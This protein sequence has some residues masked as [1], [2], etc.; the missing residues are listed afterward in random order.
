MD[1]YSKLRALSR[2][3]TVGCAFLLCPAGLVAQAA[4]APQAQLS[5]PAFRI[6]GTVV[7]AIG[8]GPLARARVTIVDARNR[9]NMQSLITSDD[10]RFDFKQVGAGKYSLQGAKRG[11]IPGLY[12]EHEQFSTAI[13]PGAGLDTENLVLRLAPY[14]VLSGKILDELGDPVREATV[15]L[16]RENRQ[17]GVGRIGKFRVTT[18]DDQ[19][20]Y[21]F[22]GLDAGSYF[23]SATAKP[24]YALHPVSSHFEGMEN[25]PTS[26]D[27]SLD[28]AY[29]VT[30]Y[31][32]S[33]EPDDATPIPI[34]GGDHLQADIHLHPVPALH[35]IFH[36]PENSDH[37][38]NMPQL[39]EPSFDGSEYMRPNEI[40][41]VSPGVFEMSGIAPGRY[42][43][44]TPGAGQADQDNEVDI[45][46]NG[47][48]LDVPTAQRTSTVKATIQVL[49]EATLPPQIE[50]ALRNSKM[51]IVAWREM[52]EKGEVEFPG[53]APGKYDVLAGSRPKA[54]SVVQMSSDGNVIAGHT[55]NVATGAS[56][57]L[58][59]S[60]AGGAVNVEG[61][62]KRAGKPT[63]GAMVVLVPKDPEANRELFR[64]DQS[65]QDGSFL[66]S[67]I[68][69]GT[70]TIVAI[71]NGWDL[72]WSR[73]GVIAHYAQHGQTITI[74]NKTQTTM[75]LPDP[76]E[77]QAR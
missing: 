22:A 75:H 25:L 37:N 1:D 36:I 64:R 62:A 74:T 24:W 55:L 76:V 33:T 3:L 30:Y 68:I 53:L 66:L 45:T 18:T 12:D 42:S 57:T 6:A 47:Q 19:G 40:Q 54:Y 69:P 44:R 17:S 61:F 20:I 70:Y 21:E 38:F 71:E 9:K 27:Q 11:F 73:P 56:M 8:G 46:T 29:P 34:R 51:R 65:D 52:D 16:Y 32:D 41:Q 58:T 49:G 7:N 72:D 5:I 4:S 35:L 15:S 39:Q 67:S 60:L 13:V 14:A 43:V 31:G 48:E 28:A 23:I 63:S 50:I 10:G 26:I 2:S 59:L 77:V